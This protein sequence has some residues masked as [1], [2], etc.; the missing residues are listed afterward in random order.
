MAASMMPRVRPRR[1][2]TLTVSEAQWA[3][4][5]AWLSL[6]QPVSLAQWSAGVYGNR[7]FHCS[8]RASIAWA[9]AASANPGA[10]AGNPEFFV[11]ISRHVPEGWR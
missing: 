2:A 7:F 6:S 8:C 3:N 4:R 9:D 10:C 5:A 1:A 11:V